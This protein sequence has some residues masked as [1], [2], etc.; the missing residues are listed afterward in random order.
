M[1]EL[2]KILQGFKFAT[3]SPVH[4]VLLWVEIGQLGA[5][6]AVLESPDAGYTNVQALFWYKPDMNVVGPVYRRTS[7]VE[8]CLIGLKGKA[9][10][11]GAQFNLSKDPVQRHNMIM[12]PSKRVLSKRICNAAAPI[13][14]HEK[15]DWLAEALLAQYARPGQWIVI[16]GFGA[17]GDVRGA[18]NAG[19][20]VVAI[21]NDQEQFLDTVAHMRNYVPDSD[22]GSV[23]T[24]DH[25]VFG[26]KNMAFH[27]E[28]EEQPDHSP[29]VCLTCNLEYEGAPVICTH[30]GNGG[31]ATCVVGTPPNCKP[32]RNPRQGAEALE[33]HVV[34]PILQ[35]EV[36]GEI[37]AKTD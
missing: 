27:Q 4:T 7:A 24:H 22:L 19:L 12:G 31:C 2:L 16:G 25:L 35:P 10:D 15:P 5:V 9:G 18:L 26:Y 37:P 30:C 1:E 21:E 29:R 28:E 14:I 32:C 8:V 34:A 11:F 36:I 33:E 13:N 3:S 6:R 23:Y 20:N 17:G